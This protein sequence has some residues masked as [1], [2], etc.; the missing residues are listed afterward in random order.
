MKKILKSAATFVIATS[1][2]ACSTSSK[3]V[4]GTFSGEAVGMGGKDHPVKV[5]L[6]LKD[7]VITD[8]QITADAETDG[9]G[10]KAME[11][12][13]KTLVSE[14]SVEVD[15]VSG[16]TIT[17]NAI[18]E[19]ALNALKAAGLKAS[20]LVAKKT[21]GKVEDMNKEVD[22]VVV[23]AGGAGMVAAITASESGKKVMII[24]SQP[25]AG[26][27]TVRSTG[28][29]NATGTKA[30]Q[31]NTFEEAAGVEKTLEK[32]KSFADHKVI[33]DLAN[34]VSEQYEAYKAN[35]TGYFDSVELMELDTMI[36]GKGKNQ[37][38]LVQTLTENSSPAIDWLS[39]IGA[40]LVSV[41]Q[42]GGASVKRIHRP[43]NDQGK[44]IAVG[45]YIVPILEKK[46]QDQ[47]IEVLY[48]TTAEKV[49]MENGQATGIMATT[50]DGAKVTV[51]AK[52]AVLATGGFGA[53]LE[54]VAEYKPELKGFVTTNAAG[55]L[56]Q[57]IAMAKEAGANL[58]DMDQIQIHP[59][60]NVTD[61]TSH[62][63]T[64]GLRGDGAILVNQEGKRFTDEVGTRDA[65]SKAEIG[66]TGGYAYL[67]IDQKMADKSNVIQGYINNGYTVS[68]QSYEELAKAMGSDEATFAET[69]KQWNQAVAE[70][71]DAQFNR[72][73][74]AEPLDQAPFYAIK[75]APGVHHT[76]GGIQINEKAQV[77]QADGQVIAGLFAAG[78]V[79]GGV[80]GA[81][82]LG[83]NAV[84][85]I[86][87]F[88]RIAGAS[89]SEF[90]K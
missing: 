89:A 2:V 75:V 29:M 47:G 82:R 62:L 88:G 10:T 49:I 42:F 6:T 11:A 86:V 78:E 68:G 44:V 31:E 4:S 72:T 12:L 81:N 21:T 8:A 59:T 63:I 43:L 52:A 32:A 23:G 35:P 41:G 65:V 3:A 55:A 14:N 77:L 67:I 36:G 51:H 28:G 40:N 46:V 5:T 70:K 13:Q 54:M 69:M 22:V 87:V 25:L 84:A 57:G 45:A 64:E 56:G 74:F 71:N 61:G 30:Q 33:M 34:K 37:F 16:A 53:N 24:E 60:V 17:S 7:N 73:T 39:S 9:I 90:V 26:G 76:M 20:D 66:Q 80:H 15:G 58:V 27:N 1:L 48:D 79:T 19:A 38:E 50:K 85:D 18:K 83:G